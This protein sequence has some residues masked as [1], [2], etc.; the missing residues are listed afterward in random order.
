MNKLK[1]GMV[2]GG[3]G[4]FI[5]DVHRKSASFDGKCDLVAGS[6]SRNFKNTL[7]TGHD[8]GLSIERLY[9]DFKEMAKKESERSDG[10]D[11]VSIVTPNFM[12]Y[13][14]AKEFLLHGISVVCEKPLT[15]EIDEAE[16]LSR[17]AK[18]RKCLF[19]VSHNFTG[20]PMVKQA[21]EI[22]KSGDIGE[23]KI[24]IGEFLTDW[25]AKA[26]A[27]NEDNMESFWRTDPSQAGKS[28][29]V[30][31]IGTHLENLIY[32]ITGLE[33][34]ELLAKMDAI[35]KGM[36]LDTNAQIIIKYKNGATG[37]Y[38]CSEMAIGKDCEA[39]IRVYGTKGSIEWH[40]QEPDLLKVTMLNQ[41]TQIYTRGSSYISPTVANMT[42]LPGG[43]LEGFY[44]SHTNIY[45][46]FADAL[47]QLKDGKRFEELD[48]EFPDVDAGADGV[49]FVNK[50]LESSNNGSSWVKFR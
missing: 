6:F 10:I 2:G 49:R 8:L 44:M 12:H 15:V 41:P 36:T 14:I 47:L 29:C 40:H 50:C 42:R 28:N 9:H 32:Y 3:K 20:Y 30:A 21:R 18:E 33:I 38:W 25:L 43:H 37:N 26:I 22:I 17:I 27:E 5:G 16:E 7:S 11:F 31:D 24:V 35:G 23:I 46:E 4:A 13:D 39:S 34:D 19:G 1:Y 48:I 45:S